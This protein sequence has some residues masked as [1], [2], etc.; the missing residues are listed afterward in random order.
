MLWRF[1]ALHGVEARRPRVLLSPH[2]SMSSGIF[3]PHVS[4][5]GVLLQRNMDWHMDPPPPAL[6]LDFPKVPSLPSARA[7][8]RARTPSGGVSRAD[9]A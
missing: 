2:G 9:P 1:I 7:Q 8:V 4:L 3:Q 5:R 6:G